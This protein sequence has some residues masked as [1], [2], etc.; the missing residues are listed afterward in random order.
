MNADFEVI[1]S[2]YGWGDPGKSS[3]WFIGIEEAAG[4]AQDP[5]EFAGEINKLRPFK[6]AHYSCIQDF[7]RDN[8][9]RRTIPNIESRIVC[10]LTGENWKEYREKRLWHEDG[11]VFHANLYPLGKA[12]L[13]QPH[14]QEILRRFGFMNADQY[15]TYVRE[16]RLDKLYT[17]WL[18][19]SPQ[20]TVCF[21]YDSKEDFERLFRHLKCSFSS[22]FVSYTDN[23]NKILLT[24]H[25]AR[26]FPAKTELYITKKLEEWNVSFK[27]IKG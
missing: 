5:L 7:A 6:E 16:S 19:N 13:S 9:G 12:S 21:G 24:P 14:S 10:A 27:K 3:I 26:A 1:D 22:D 20:A 17:F 25:F 8:I 11:G 15:M 4:F 18:A 23:E 2:Y